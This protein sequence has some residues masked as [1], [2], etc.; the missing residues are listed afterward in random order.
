[1]KKT[2]TECEVLGLFGIDREQVTLHRADTLS[3]KTA[4][5]YYLPR[6]DL[7]TL[8][9][10]KAAAYLDSLDPNYDSLSLLVGEVEDSPG[11]RYGAWEWDEESHC[12]GGIEASWMPMMWLDGSTDC[13]DFFAECAL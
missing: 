6:W 11:V 10:G 2:P 12:R 1:M 7:L 8:D 3:G 9:A 5:C 4:P 13:D